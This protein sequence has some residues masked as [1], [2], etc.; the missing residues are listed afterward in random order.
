M[1][2]SPL[3]QLVFH[4]WVA[5]TPRNVPAFVSGEGSFLV[6]DA[7][8]RYLDFSSQLVFTNVGH[9]HPGWSR[10]SRTR[11]TVCARS[12]PPGRATYAVRRRR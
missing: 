2:I 11:L 6:D 3:D 12:P 4:P 10:R 9:Q 5:Q 8:R 7:G 1:D